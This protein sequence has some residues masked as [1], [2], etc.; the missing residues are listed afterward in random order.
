MA[1]KNKYDMDF[2][3]ELLD[4]FN[5]LPDKAKELFFAYCVGIIHGNKSDIQEFVSIIGFLVEGDSPIEQIFAFAYNLVL[6]DNDFIQTEWAKYETQKEISVNNRKYR[7]DFYFHTPSKNG[8]LDL[9]VECDGHD[10]HKLTKQQVEKDNERDFDLKRA[11]YEVIHFSGSQIYKDPYGCAEQ[12]FEY[13][14][15]K[16]DGSL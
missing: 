5:K 13:L 12:V 8:S 3:R 14:K 2:G 9:I 10:F 11:G 7:A 4:D 1:E 6:W 16:C 15:G